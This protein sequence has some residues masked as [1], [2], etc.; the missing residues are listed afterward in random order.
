MRLEFLFVRY[1]IRIL[2]SIPPLLI[3]KGTLSATTWDGWM[4]KEQLNSDEDPLVMDPNIIE[5]AVADQ[6][7][8]LDGPRLTLM[9]L[10]AASVEEDRVNLASFQGSVF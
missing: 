10:R 4:E 5:A 3:A 9:D 8:L 2:T 7:Q 6:L 1:Q